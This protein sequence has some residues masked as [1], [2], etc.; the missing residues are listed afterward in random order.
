MPYGDMQYVGK[1]CTG[2][3]EKGLG[4]RYVNSSWIRICQ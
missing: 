1:V 3:M 4:L 2:L